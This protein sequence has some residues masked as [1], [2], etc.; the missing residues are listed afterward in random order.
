M[1]R[2]KC[3]EGRCVLGSVYQAR[4]ISG[5][6]FSISFRHIPSLLAELR[7]GLTCSCVF[8]ISICLP[9]PKGCYGIHDNAYGSNQTSCVTAPGW[10]VSFRNSTGCT[11]I[12]RAIMHTRSSA[13][14][15]EAVLPAR[16]AP[17][18]VDV[19]D[20]AVYPRT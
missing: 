15:A 17:G 4:L 16:L 2:A 14:S 20:A 5:C 1:F 9:A 19:V 13:N 10:A 3:F 11:I 12:A 18:I 7:E 6:E 8:L